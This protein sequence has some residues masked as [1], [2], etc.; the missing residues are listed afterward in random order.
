[1][2]A[3]HISTQPA[4]NRRHFLKG[5]GSCVALPFLDAM[6]PAFRA[7]AANV[8]AVPRF[9]AMNAALGIHAGHFFPEATGNDYQ[10][11]PYLEKL[12]DHRN[13]FTVF[14]RSFTCESE[15]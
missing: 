2:K 15:R 5:I 8:V 10:L 9:M 12:K 1:M 3:P 4:L 7:K 14:F 11:T 13:D 6:I